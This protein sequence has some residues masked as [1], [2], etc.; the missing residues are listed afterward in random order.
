LRRRRVADIPGFRNIR[1]LVQQPVAIGGIV[2]MHAASTGAAL[3]KRYTLELTFEDDQVANG[4]IA[5]KTVNGAKIL[6]P[7]G[8]VARELD[9]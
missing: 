4:R 9:E 6:F 2:P 1:L 7:R 3:E 8:H 5:C